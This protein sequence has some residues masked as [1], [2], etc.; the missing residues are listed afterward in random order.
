M[1]KRHACKTTPAK[2]PR[3]HQLLQDA[4]V[5]PFLLH[6]RRENA[7]GDGGQRHVKHHFSIVYQ[8]ALNYE[9]KRTHPHAC[10]NVGRASQGEKQDNH[11]S[12]QRRSKP[13]YIRRGATRTRRRARGRQYDGAPIIADPRRLRLDRPCGRVYAALV[14]T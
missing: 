14:R 7:D 10:Y 4:R 12:G 13:S 2:L 1:R 5:F 8:A 3:V 11:D 6:A 9:K